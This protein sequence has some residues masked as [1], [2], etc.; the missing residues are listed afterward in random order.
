MRLVRNPRPFDRVFTMTSRPV[1]FILLLLASCGGGRRE[2]E[3]VQGTDESRQST[4]DSTIRT[5]HHVW[6]AG[7][8]ATVFVEIRFRGAKQATVR[9]SLTLT[10]VQQT[11]APVF[12]QDQYWAPFDITTGSTG[13]ERE[14]L[15][16]TDET[17]PLSIRLVPSR[18]LWAASK[19]SVWPSQ[20]LEK[21]VP[22]GKYLLRVEVEIEP[23]KTESSNEVAVTIE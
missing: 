21:A 19:S 7:E 23:G 17:Q 13:R 20:P 15:Q 3:T 9:P 11:A 8:Q 16:S 1:L 14:L 18:L 5:T 2:G 12:L 4:I 6:R 10:S 22:R